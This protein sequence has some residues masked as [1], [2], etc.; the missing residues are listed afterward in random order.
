ME[1]EIWKD[2]K[3]FEGLYQISNLGRVK[4]LQKLYKKPQSH[5]R[6]LSLS[7]NSSGY[8]SVYL[9][10]SNGR[11]HRYTIHRLVA[12]AFID[13]PNNY[14]CINHKDENKQ[15]NRVDNL[16]WCSYSYNNA[17]GT[18][19]IRGRITKSNPVSQFTKEGIWIATYVTPSIA[20]ELL[21]C[22]RH[23]IVRCCDNENRTALGYIRKWAKKPSNKE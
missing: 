17:Y 2:I 20:A 23:T 4:S 9:R 21:K 22:E 10:S 5:Y 3:G 6:I 14:P 19:R 7:L 13:N 1:Q 12:N 16:E 15:N 11:D 8:L 18:A